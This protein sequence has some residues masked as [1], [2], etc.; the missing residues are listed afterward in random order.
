MHFSILCYHASMHYWK[1]SS[2][3]PSQ[4]CYYG[5]LDSL[6]IFK[7]GS[8]GLEEMKTVTEQDQVNKEVVLV[9]LCSSLPRTTRCSGHSEQVHCRGEAATICP[10]TTVASFRVPTQAY[11]TGSPFRH[12]DFWSYGKNSQGTMPFTSMNVIYMIVLLSSVL[13]TSETSTDCSSAWFPGC[14]QKFMSNQQ[15]WLWSKSGSVWTS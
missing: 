6:H 2:E 1:E 3:M 15:W 5:P 7:M 11:I 10:T 4:F 9:W 8:L 14:T 13:V 12:T